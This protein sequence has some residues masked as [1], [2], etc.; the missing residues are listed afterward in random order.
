LR[1]SLRHAGEP[2]P[3]DDALALREIDGVVALRG[4]AEMFDREL[5]V[6][7]EVGFELAPRLIEALRSTM[8]LWTSIAQR[9]ASTTLR[10]SMM[11]P[12]P[13]PRWMAMIGS[14]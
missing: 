3:F 1:S 13:R 6:D 10:N 11:L 5:G 7:G 12:S 4:G 9:T 8:A 2:Y 14:R